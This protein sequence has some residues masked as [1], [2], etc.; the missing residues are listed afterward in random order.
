[1]KF[2]TWAA[3]RS[4][5]PNCKLNNGLFFIDLNEGPIKFEDI[6]GLTSRQIAA[7]YPR[8]SAC[9]RDI[10]SSFKR[11]GYIMAATRLHHL[12]DDQLLTYIKDFVNTKRRLPTSRDFRFNPDLPHD[13]SYILRFGSWNKAIKKAGFEPSLLSGYGIKTLGKDNILY[14]SKFEALFADKFLYEKHNY[15]YEPKYPAPFQSLMYDFFVIDK[16]LYIELN[17]GLREQRTTEKVSINKQLNR[18]CIFVELHHLRV[19]SLEELI[20]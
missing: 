15:Q 17:G 4:H 1:M 5:V 13:D 3:V 9:I 18:K 10:R 11:R 8:L 19:N 6:N 12:S 20:S 16:N 14:R 2:A 7:T